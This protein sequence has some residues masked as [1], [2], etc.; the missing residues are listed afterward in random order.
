MRTL[1]VNEKGCAY[2]GVEQAVDDTAAG[3]SA[4]GHAVHLLSCE[5]IAEG[6]SPLGA[7]FASRTRLELQAAEGTWRRQL[8]RALEAAAPDV[9]YVHRWAHR[10]SLAELA[11][12]L[13]TVR[14]VHDHDLYCPRRHKYFPLSR[15]I[16][17]HPLGVHCVLHG[18]LLTPQGP[19]PGLPG[20]V[21]LRAKARD[22][23]F[24]RRLPTLAVGSRWMRDMMRR[25]GFAESQVVLLPPV[26]AGLER[27]TPAPPA[28]GAVPTVLFVGQLIRGKGVDLLLAAL[29]GVRRPFRALLVGTGAQQHELVEQT[30]QLGL[31]GRVTFVGWVP[32]DRLAD[33]YRQAT[34]VAV[35]SR[36]PEPFG[37]VGLEAM[38]SARPVAAFAVGG[39]PDWLV[40]GET[41]L[42]AA[43]G[44]A[45]GLGHALEE[46]LSDADLG[47]RLGE[48]GF[49]RAREHYRF[50]D[51]LERTA[52][53]LA[54]AVVGAGASSGAARSSVA[55]VSRDGE[56][57]DDP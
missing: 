21:D 16:C 43:E 19:V 56:E 42:L 13:P 15:R 35:P 57:I 1:F 32:H 8:A 31:G 27:D 25:N 30:R 2:G 14:Y 51:Y 23:A 18:C 22:L 7:P 46:L 54:G 41:G 53:L 34:V 6:R 33:Y 37:M 5:P 20:L 50:A 17:N 9:V 28:D 52:G 45:K 3:L 4:R 10:E 48:A 39:I 24:N 12:G 40:D 55:R 26:P 47:R 11:A 36:W 49:A 38:W 29:A 44:D